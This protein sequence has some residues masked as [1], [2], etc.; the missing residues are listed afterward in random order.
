MTKKLTWEQKTI[1]NHNT[2]HALVKAVPG[3]GKTTTLVKR[4]ERLIKSGTDPRSILI[5]MYNKSAQ[6]SFADKLKIVLKSKNIPEVRTFHSLALKIVTYAERRQIIEKKK[7]ITS[8]NPYYETLVK[9]AYRRGFEYEDNYIAPNAIEDFELFISRCRADAVTSAD[10]AT[11]PTFS[12]IK[13]E[14]ILSFI[15]YSELLEKNNLRTF[16]DYLIESASVLRNY[17]SIGTHFRH[18]I[19]D[20]YQDVNL[21]QHSIIRYLS[22]PDTSVMA[23]GDVNQCIYEWRGARPDFIDGL[24]EKHFDNTKIFQL[25]CTFRFGHQLSLIANSVIR[26]NSTKLNRLCVSHPSTPKTKVKIHVDNS[27]FKVLTDISVEKGTLAILARTKASLAEA[28][29]VL[30]LCGLPY[31]YLNGSASLHN[32]SEIGMLVVGILL[33]LYGDLQLLE[34]HPSRQALIYGFLREVGFRWQKG[35]FKA[36]LNGLMVTRTPDIIAVLG[37]LFNDDISSQHQKDHLKKLSSICQKGSE[38]TLA[39]DVLVQLKNAGFINNNGSEGITRKGANDKQRGAVKIEA[40][41]KSTK[42]DSKRFLELILHPTDTISTNC[43]PFIL[44]TL[45]G[46][47]GLEWDNLVLFGLNDEEYPGEIVDDKYD[48]IQKN[49][50]PEDDFSI[51][52]DRRLFYVGITRAK[53][54]LTLV[55]PHDDG[56]NRWLDNGW[57]S[58]PKKSPIATRFIYEAGCTACKVTSDIIYANEVETRKSELTKFHQWYLKDF[59]R[60]KV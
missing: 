2:G 49:S 30:R 46:S 14:L 31:R 41:L 18:I 26:R 12:N 32:R 5:L 15:H 1:V 38:T 13:R 8:D 19:V 22:K 60:L 36:A 50:A 23:V 33:S 58:T 3:S 39:Y 59:Q 24:F 54:I 40:L 27:L 10:V 57:D 25:S 53:R 16:D 42:I 20:E 43:E 17:P 4:I 48:I 56:L 21:V 45:H 37:A 7:L 34:C 55:V 51:E 28:E 29:V 52:E 35:Q 9:E 6:I 44:S 47:K 11:D